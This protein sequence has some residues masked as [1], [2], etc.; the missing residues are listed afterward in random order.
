MNEKIKPLQTPALMGKRDEKTNTYIV[1]TTASANRAQRR[2]YCEAV[3]T[4]TAHP[5]EV[6]FALASVACTVHVTVARG[7]TLGPSRTVAPEWVTPL[8]DLI[9]P[10]GLVTWH[11]RDRGNHV[12][13]HRQVG[14]A[15]VALVAEVSHRERDR[16]RS[17]CLGAGGSCTSSLRPA[18]PIGQE[19]LVRDTQPRHAAQRFPSERG[20]LAAVCCWRKT[21]PN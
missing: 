19:K 8:Q 5:K 13:L 9:C 4:M 7:G 11:A 17:Q 16:H 1:A 2:D 14:S 20:K 10:P 18:A 15:L 6:W 3:V 21:L 12:I